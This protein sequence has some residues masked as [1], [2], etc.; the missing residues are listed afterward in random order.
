MIT[1]QKMVLSIFTLALV[2]AMSQGVSAFADLTS[3]EVSGVEGLGGQDIAVFAGESVPVRIIFSATQNANDV[4]IKAWISGSREYAVTTE[5]FDVLNGNIYS[6]LLSVPLPFDLNSKEERFILQ[7]AV[8]SRN[9]GVGDEADIDLVVQR[10]SYLVE[11]LDVIMPTEVSTGNPLTLDI[12]LKNR[13]RQNAEDTFV[14][15]R[16]PALNIEERAYFGDLSPIDQANPDKEDAVERGLIINIPRNAPAG[17]YVLELEAYNADS[18]S[19]VVK[20]F[21]ITGAD[22]DTIIMPSSTS[23]TFSAGDVAGYKVTIVNAGKNVRVYDFVIESAAG[24]TN[25]LDESAVVVPAGTSRTVTLNAK[26]SKSGNYNFAL[27]VN[28]N[29]E[30]VKRIPLTANVAGSSFGGNSGMLLLTVVLA[31][32]FVVLLVVLIV[33]LTKQPERS[34]KE[35]YY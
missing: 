3:I 10:D 22:S 16:I 12:V 34:E 6:K 15:A 4:R 32:I 19:K 17:T 25:E 31:I 2:L 1:K 21:T 20:R 8:E 23:K 5:R 14:K 7:V 24:L 33:L 27:A 11:L 28:S 29:G 13:G 35:S 26:A 18:V 9:G 30:L